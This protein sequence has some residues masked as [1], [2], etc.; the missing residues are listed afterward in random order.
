MADVMGDK[1]DSD[2]DTSNR[3]GTARREKSYAA[4]TSDEDPRG[5]NNDE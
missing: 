2:S 5:G 3:K 1:D 4:E